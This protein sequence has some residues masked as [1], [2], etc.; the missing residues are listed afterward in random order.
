MVKRDY[1]DKPLEDQTMVKVTVD[2]FGEE[3]DEPETL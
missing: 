2:T 3:F 1:L